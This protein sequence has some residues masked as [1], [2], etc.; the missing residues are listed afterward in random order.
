[1]SLHACYIQEM[2]TWFY[3]NEINEQF[4]LFVVLQPKYKTCNSSIDKYI[5][6]LNLSNMDRRKERIFLYQM[7]RY[8]IVGIVFA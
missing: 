7:A 4:S 8:K 2:V 3:I 1:M 5:S 6:S